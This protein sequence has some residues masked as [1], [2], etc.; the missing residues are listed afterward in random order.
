VESNFNRHIEG[1]FRRYLQSITLSK[2]EINIRM[3]S[4]RTA[5]SPN[6]F[7]KVAASRGGVGKSETDG[8]FGINNEN[9]PDLHVQM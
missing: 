3:L 4:P 1:Q 5:S 8:L 9:R 7:V 2:G 6:D